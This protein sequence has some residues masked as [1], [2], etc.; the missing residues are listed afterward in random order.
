M[1]RANPGSTDFKKIAALDASKTT[2]TTF[3]FTDPGRY[4]RSI[5]YVSAFNGAGESQSTPAQ[6]TI[7]EQ[8]CTQPDQ[9]G[10]AVQA[11][12]ITTTAQPLERAFCYASLDNGA[13]SRMPPNPE[14]YVYPQ[15]GA[16]DFSPYLNALVSPPPTKAVTLTMRCGGFAGDALIDLGVGQQT[17][18]PNSNNQPFQ[19]TGQGFTLTATLNFGQALAPV[20]LPPPPAEP[21]QDRFIAPPYDVTVFTDPDTGERTLLW[22]WRPSPPCDPTAPECTDIND[23]TGFR[24]YSFTQSI[25]NSSEKKVVTDGLSPA[26]RQFKLPPLTGDDAKYGVYYLLVAYQDIYES[27]QA[28]T[29]VGGIGGPAHQPLPSANIPAPTNLRM[30]GDVAVCQS[31]FEV[32]PVDWKENNACAPLAETDWQTRAFVWE[33]S[34]TLCQPGSPGCQTITNIDGYHIYVDVNGQQRLFGS[35]SPTTKATVQFYAHQEPL[36][37]FVV[38]AYKGNLESASSNKAC[39]TMSDVGFT[40]NTMPPTAFYQFG[41]TYT[42]TTC[43]PITSTQTD[44]P[45]A[46]QTTFYWDSRAGYGVAVGYMHLTS[47]P[48][49]AC[50][51]VTALWREGLATFDLNQL[52]STQIQTATLVFNRSPVHNFYDTSGLFPDDFV[53][54]AVANE[55]DCATSL[56]TA[57]SAYTGGLYR[58]GQLVKA[59]PGSLFTG[60]QQVAAA[61]LSATRLTPTDDSQDDTWGID[62]TSL[63]QTAAQSPGKVL[64]L[65]F[66]TDTSHPPETASCL[67]VYTAIGLRVTVTP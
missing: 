45:G 44:T 18:Q 66:A 30:T 42:G 51:Q 34:N 43:D 48:D 38:R 20:V 26:Q 28:S 63:A 58:D 57:V 22:R 13:W 55:K 52:G 2:G 15:N 5:Y 3:S 64:S 29:S 40:D 62:V 32:K 17:I 39:M 61:P 10:L 41:S 49:P 14:T 47:G 16:F 1:Y 53:A 24:V 11:P 21:S 7:F 65:L 8:T 23:I 60:S 19:L 36:N 35:S 9:V 12:I 56:D 4:G 54:N 46:A 59:A 27:Q 37:C 31:H 6:A 33:W 25:Q 50:P 67:S